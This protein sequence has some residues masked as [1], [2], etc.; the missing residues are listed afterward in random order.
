MQW[1]PRESSGPI[2]DATYSCDSQSIF[3]SVEDGSV[4]ILTAN[5]LRI[6][7][8]ISPAAYLPANPRYVLTVNG[9]Y[10]QTLV[11][12]AH[13]CITLFFLSHSTRVHP[14]VV[15]AHPSEPNQFAVGLTDG[16]IHVLEPP[17]SEGKWGTAPPV[18]NGAGP[19]VTSAGGAMEQ[20]SR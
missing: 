19:S 5:T 16:G 20:E 15:A 7:C 13:C 1:L 10:I 12:D 17:E 9:I 14:V 6:R 18:E 8:R 3:A 11:A 4:Y 2:T